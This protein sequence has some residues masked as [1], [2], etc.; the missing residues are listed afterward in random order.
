M[1]KKAY[2]LIIG[3]ALSFSA[4]SQFIELPLLYSLR[5][6]F[7]HQAAL[8]GDSVYMDYAPIYSD[9]LSSTEGFPHL[10]CDTISDRNWLGRKFFNENLI[11]LNKKNIYLTLDPIF[12]FSTGVDLSDSLSTTLYTNTR[13]IKIE[14]VLGKNIL[15]STSFLENQ[16][17]FPN[18]VNT[19]IES[20]GVVPGMG[21][22]KDY[23]NKDYD[24]AIAMASISWKVSDFLRIKFGNDKDFLGFGYRSIL[25]TDNAFS[26]P[27]LKL[28]FYFAKQKLKY[29]LNYALLQDLIRLPK[30]ET[31]ESLFERKVGAFHYLSYLPNRK[32]SIGLFSGT[33]LP[34]TA[35]D[36]VNN[37]YLDALNPILMMNPLLNNPNYINKIGLN[38]SLE[39]WKNT[40]FYFQFAENPSN[41]DQYSLLAGFRTWDLLI[42]GLNLTLEYTSSKEESAAV[43]NE[44]KTKSYSH[45]SQSLAHVLG[46]G[47]NEIF[48]QIDYRYKHIYFLLSLN[49]AERNVLDGQ[50][51]GFIDQDVQIAENEDLMASSLLINAE[52]S[53]L[54]N[55]KTNMELALGY[56]VKRSG[57]DSI[58]GKT[59]YLYLAFRTSLFNQYVD[60]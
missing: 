24:Y 60:F 3:I 15:F 58:F 42:P 52:L 34:N 9:E 28:D 56:R 17:H 39:I 23:K 49:Y 2:S 47:F 45:Y 6:E 20:N 44:G 13:G 53:Y 37:F 25:L 10:I 29:T 27:H 46:S 32:F 18:Y 41:W 57:M 51:W 33:I 38:L 14:G 55:S 40:R 19:F 35:V 54:F 16:A 48:A 21:R 8:N 11:I 7:F 59:D 4:Y 31:P 1:I 43:L 36:S 5:S 26:Y 12:N 22:V 30:G 50:F